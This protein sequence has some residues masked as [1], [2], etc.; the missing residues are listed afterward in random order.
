[1]AT[2]GLLLVALL[3]GATFVAVK[4][5]LTEL[6]P[7]LFVAVRFGIAAVCAIPLLRGAGLRAGLRWGV[8]IGAILAPAY[9]AQT[10][11]L[12]T[13]TPSRSAFITGAGVVLIPLWGWWVLRRRPGWYPV[14]GL[15]IALAGVWLLTDPSDGRWRTGDSW[16]VLCAVL[17]ALHVVLLA[18]FGSSHHV[19]GLVF[20]QLLTCAVISGVAVPGLEPP[21]FAW[22]SGVVTALLVT[23]VLASFVTTLLQLKLLPRVTPARAAV[24]FSSEPVFAALFSA[25]LFGES[26]GLRGWGGGALVLCGMLVSESAIWDANGR[27]RTLA[28]R[29]SRPAAPGGTSL[30]GDP[31]AGS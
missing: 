13:T 19:G 30:P 14:A 1:M 17:F 23:G 5:A 16:T 18:R 8:P 24:L 25:G 22:T 21:R 6:S 12:V 11:G 20:S 2:L 4:S 27:W 15:A 10:V 7:V 26:L 3:W 28:A 29:R 31:P 9:L